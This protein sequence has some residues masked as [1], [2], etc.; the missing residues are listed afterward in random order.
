MA[1]GRRLAPVCS[2]CTWM[3]IS[4]FRAKLDSA[5]WDLG[6]A[7]A[8]GLIDILS[9]AYEIAAKPIPLGFPPTPLERLLVL[10]DGIAR[11]LDL[12]DGF[13]GEP[14]LAALY[15]REILTKHFRLIQHLE[16]KGLGLRTVL[17]GG[18]RI[19]YT[20]ERTTGKELL[21][22]APSGPVS[23]QGRQ[24]VLEE[25]LYHPAP[26]QMNTAFSRAYLIERSN[27]ERNSVY[28][29]E[30][31]VHLLSQAIPGCVQVEGDSLKGQIHIQRSGISLIHFTYQPRQQLEQKLPTHVYRI[32]SFV[33]H[34]AFDG[35]EVEFPLCG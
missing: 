8:R 28:F 21:P 15:L 35:D 4:G 9:D 10:N 6:T 31:F 33:V 23:E 18:H 34:Q 2:V 1:Q 3:D 12:P 7:Q 20:P 24:F 22:T 26:F 27:I 19:Q 13:Q 32:T 16:L 14:F 29:D 25:F 30:S 5:N 11:V 17:A